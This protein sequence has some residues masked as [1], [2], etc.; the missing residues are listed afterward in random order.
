VIAA[1]ALLYA[2][3]VWFATGLTTPTIPALQCVATL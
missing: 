1:A 3:R 2:A